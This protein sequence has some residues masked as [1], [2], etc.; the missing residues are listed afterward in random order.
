MNHPD[1]GAA[2]SAGGSDRIGR[3]SRKRHPRRPAP[4]AAQNHAATVPPSRWRWVRVSEMIG[5][6]L[7]CE[8]KWLVCLYG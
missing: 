4:A 1:A 3:K 8:E 2:I 5:R 6:W 7:G